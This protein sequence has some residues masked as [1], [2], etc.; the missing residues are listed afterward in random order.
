[1]KRLK[2][3]DVEL[4]IGGKMVAGLDSIEIGR[5]HV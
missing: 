4:T 5:A 1:M 3:T 2:A